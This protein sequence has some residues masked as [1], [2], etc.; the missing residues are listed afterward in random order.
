MEGRRPAALACALA[1]ASALRPP[2]SQSKLANDKYKFIVNE[3]KMNVRA[4]IK[5]HSIVG[6]VQGDLW[7][8]HCNLGDNEC[9]I[10]EGTKN[11][12][13]SQAP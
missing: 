5:P 4:S 9:K 6:W 3:K 11:Q 2:P 12:L 13:Y 1:D 10:P 8:N 7:F